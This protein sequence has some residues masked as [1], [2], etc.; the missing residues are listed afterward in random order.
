MAENGHMMTDGLRWICTQYDL[1][2]RETESYVW[3]GN[4]VRT[5]GADK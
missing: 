2:E 4:I 3:T 5:A 1:I